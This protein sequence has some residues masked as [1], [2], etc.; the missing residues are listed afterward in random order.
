[1]PRYLSSNKWLSHFE[2]SWPKMEL[3]KSLE[4]EAEDFA[5]DVL[6]SRLLVIHDPGRRRHHDETK[7]RGD[8]LCK[9]GWGKERG[10]HGEGKKF[11]NRQVW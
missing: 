2:R 4:E 9:L 11:D 3:E 5:S 6:P 8:E 10:I 1:M 7:L